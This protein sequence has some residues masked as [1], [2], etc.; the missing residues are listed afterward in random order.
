MA[1][2]ILIV[3]YTLF[4]V[5]CKKN[6]IV[7]ATPNPPDPDLKLPEL[8]TNSESAL[9]Y[10]SVILSGKLIDSGG[11]NIN[12]LGF[13]IDTVPMPTTSK[14]LNKIL[15]YQYDSDGTFSITATYLPQTTTFYVRSY[16]INSNG[17][18]YGNQITFTSLF[19]RIFPA[20]VTL[21]SQEEV[22]DFG[23]NHYTTIDGSL[24]I[25][26]TVSDLTP[27]LGLSIINYGL[28]VTNSLIKN[29]K[30]LDSLEITGAI[31]PNDFWVENNNNLVNFSGLSKLKYS[32]GDVQIDNNNSLRD[33]DG[34]DSYV[35]ANAGLLRIGECK[36]LQNLNG[37]KNM[38]FVGDN[39]Y[40]IDNP[41]LTDIT[42][43]SNV[44]TITGRLYII[45]NSVLK[46]LNGLEKIEN[47]PNGIEID[48]N[49]SLHDLSGLR[50]LSTINSSAGIGTITIDGNPMISDLSVFSQISSVDYVY[51][52]N[53]NEL[54]NLSG[55]SN[56]QSVRNFLH[57]ENNSGLIDLTGLE[58]L[59]SVGRLEILNNNA[60][61]NL[62][63]LNAL[64][65][66]I[67]NGN[68]ITIALN[69]NLQSLTG[70]E[71]LI[72]ADG[73][74]QISD[75]TNLADFCPLKTLFTQGYNQFFS[76]ANNSANPTQ[77]D[78]VSNCP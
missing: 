77:N 63:G 54:K 28:I 8:I 7:P 3:I 17:T 25:N 22:D 51:I 72:D 34:L 38:T 43:L 9:T 61:I 36:K 41:S 75:N 78:I 66:I 70:L 69:S 58:K 23:A 5:A 30:G 40:I 68:S 48:N 73:S 67:N 39:F 60:L 35:A 20:N 76:S 10:F 55:L 27:L 44:K 46:N 37:L 6:D 42:G 14:N 24:H 13:V 65:K 19:Q 29:F 26:G 31:L 32:R 74:I 21:S 57:I 11:V 33:L 16:A 18:G 64:T 52:Q 49:L 1:K 71:N 53:N 4:I 45:N 56:L 12:E 62:T 59:T 50:N 15:I 2:Y 47:L